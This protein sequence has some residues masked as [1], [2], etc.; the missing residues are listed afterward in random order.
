MSGQIIQSEIAEIPEV[1]SRIISQQKIFENAVALIRA[2]EI[3]NVVI[4][5]R[6][7]SAHAGLFLKTLIETE[8]GLPVGLAFPSAVSINGAKLNYR[9]SLVIGISQSGQS[10]DLL[11]YLK[12][13]A[14]GGAL[15]ITMTNDA[16]SPMAKSA[17]LHLDLQAKPEKALAATKSY[18]AQLL[19][20][21]LL[22]RT[23]NIDNRA[24]TSI[25]S[26]A[27]EILKRN[28]I[29]ESLIKDINSRAN[30][31]F[32]G[33]GFGLANAREGALKIQETSFKFIQ[34]FS[35]ADYIHGP[36]AA[37]DKDCTV[38]FL[39]PKASAINGL[40]KAATE[41]RQRGAKAIWLG[42]GGAPVSGETVVR[43]SESEDEAL[44]CVVDATLIQI[45]AVKLSLS[46]GHNP[47]TSRGLNKVT[48]TD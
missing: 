9:N 39:A 20:S 30:L 11:S 28:E 38:I 8:M 47:D 25:S 24:I 2:R 26:Y 15:V 48:L 29:S 42:S 6:G 1:F 31:I 43:G 21:L 36:M 18:S 13:A 5:A 17:E 19:T 27:S 37:V 12:A 4:V 44:N 34:G 45:L 3:N 7:T 32:V 16:N 10:P 33:R 41:T 40:E 22:V 23:W 46:L 14:D 35:A